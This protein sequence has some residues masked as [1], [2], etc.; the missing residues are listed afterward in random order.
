[1]VRARMKAHWAMGGIGAESACIYAGLII[2]RMEISSPQNDAPLQGAPALPDEAT[3]SETAASQ[4]APS[5]Y[6][7]EAFISYRHLPRDEE[8]ARKV[9]RAI[10]GF[11]L[12]KG[13]M[14]TGEQGSRKLGKCFRDADELAASPSLPASIH[15]ALAQSRCLIVVCSP[16]AAESP[17]VQREIEAFAA[18][19][20]T[21]RI[22]PVLAS[23]TSQES[24]PPAMRPA[25]NPL[26]LRGSDQSTAASPLA[27]DLRATGS[28]GKQRAET[29]R[30]IAAVAGCSYDDL[31][32]RE[33]ARNRKRV[34][35]GAAMAT[36]VLALIIALGAQAC[37]SRADALAAESE[38]LA[39]ASTEQ[40]AR[41]ERMQAIQTALSALPSSAAG[42]ERP[43]VPA[44]QAALE[45]ALEVN[46]DP[47]T[48]W[49]PSFVI[50]APAPIAC[51]VAD[52]S[53]DWAATL[54]ETGSIGIYS[55][56]TGRGLRSI[57]LRGISS[58]PEQLDVGEW[59]IAAA[60]PDRVV[61]ANRQG[62]G[63]MACFD[64]AS[65]DMLWQH[66]AAVVSSLSVSDDG[67][68][69]ALFT[70]APEEGIVAGLVD[71]ATGDALA[72]AELDNPAFLDFP[73]FLPSCLDG[74]KACLATGG[75]LVIADFESATME[76]FQMN[77]MMAWSAQAEGGIA[78][79]ASSHPT[80]E[81]SPQ[82]VV[83]EVSAI[84]LAEGSIGWTDRASY[85]YVAVGEPYRA[86]TITGDPHAWG[87]LRAGGEPAVAW[88]AGSTLHVSLLADG[89][90]AA[91]YDFPSPIVGTGITPTTDGND[92]LCM[93]TADGT[94]DARLIG[95]AEAAH[96]NA[97]REAIPYTIG[98]AI[99]Q[100]QHGTE[101]LAIMQALDQPQRLVVYHQDS[102][103]QA[104]PREYGLDEL[105]A[106]AHETL[107]E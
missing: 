89:H 7:Y 104:E 66:E 78:V 79:I 41:G 56:E 61:A 37:S 48:I 20:G 94:L 14:R 18:L 1:M 19:H 85:D 70:V 59:T 73:F 74:A 22:F 80:T 11:R 54:D 98:S 42:L 68:Q 44:A 13:A 12:P 35:T 43:L 31:R 28:R 32:R 38:Q 102:D 100:W 60:G 51:F 81:R 57:D 103:V 26:R 105:I 99:M 58:S 39:A 33:A 36:L 75:T 40:L 87:F 62:N 10:E 83:A 82:S 34:A 6:K 23:G 90:D 3:P 101:L 2:K 21:A 93:A 63:A 92:T 53:A 76:A 67:S 27:A 84:D 17:W 91:S 24:I 45:A 8:V 71:A 69:V 5:S 9:Q 95:V 96:G 16:D 77:D 86:I 97:F 64:A 15:E 52:P 72:W 65:G 25:E 107:G 4:S 46:P 49:R 30:L 47:T 50:D 88:S 106:L 29:L 55:L